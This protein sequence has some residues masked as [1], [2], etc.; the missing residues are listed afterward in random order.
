M[1]HVVLECAGD[2]R[3]SPGAM[4]A[5]LGPRGV[6]LHAKRP[7]A[8][9]ARRGTVAMKAAERAARVS[10]EETFAIDAGRD[11]FFASMDR[12]Q[13]LAIL[14]V[15]PGALEARD[16]RFIAAERLKFFPCEESARG[17]MRFVRAFDVAT[18][19][20]Y[21]LE[22]R[23]ARR[24]AV[25]SLGRHRGAFCREE[26]LQFLRECLTESD[27]YM[28]ETAVWALGE[29]GIAEEPDALRDILA[30][31][32]NEEV[33]HRVVIQTLMRAAYTPAIPRIRTFV[34]SP[35][36]ATASAAMTAVALLGKEPEAMAPVVELLTSTDLNVRRAVIEDI[37]LSRF[38]PA[39][40]KVAVTPN[41]LVLRARTV[42]TLLDAATADQ[43][44]PVA[45]FSEHTAALVDRLIWDHPGDLNLLGMRKAT[46]K[47]RDLGRNVRQ[48]YKNDAVFPYLAARTLAEDH[49]GAP[50]GL[51]GAAVL[52]SYTDLEYFDYFGAY[53]AYK[54]LG[55][56]QYKPAYNVLLDNAE[57][58]PPRFFNHAAGAV[59]ALAEIGIKDAI[60][61]LHRIPEK[62]SIWELKYACLVAAE[63]IGDDGELRR[64]LT[65]DD[66]WLVRA[67]ARCPLDFTHLRNS[68]ENEL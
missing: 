58:L 11:L 27:K 7:T 68:F 15:L 45:G 20:E 54:T 35:D 14:E 6:V 57:N 59:T 16:D 41:S 44:D 37:T 36:A 22:D 53:H 61:A 21:L 66:D 25:E 29:V 18:I 19:A 24:K 52:K 39:L 48:L 31:L 62:T 42:R 10:T 1:G 38:V 9:C 26:I 23:V 28:V 67:R 64:K 46:K 30:V 65:G 63:R 32:E 17:I 43:E 12:D 8:R 4:V 3:E 49:R 56:L 33:A 34:Q 2:G 60:P 51:A 47:A 50:D 13:A 5:F 40:Q 55:W